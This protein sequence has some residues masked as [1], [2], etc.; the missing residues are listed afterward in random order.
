MSTPAVSP[1][2]QQILHW[3][4]RCVTVSQAKPIPLLVTTGAPTEETDQ[5]KETSA[6]VQPL[7]VFA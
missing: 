7:D 2:Y 6:D 3:Y 4:Q 1:A 5:P